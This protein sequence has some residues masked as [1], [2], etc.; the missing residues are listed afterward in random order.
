MVY[1]H[2][3]R[4]PLCGRKDVGVY[5]LDGFSLGLCTHG[6]YS[7][8]F[9]Q[10]VKQKRA[11][12]EI[13]QSALERILA[14]GIPGT[15]QC[16]EFLRNLVQYLFGS[17]KD[18]F[19]VIEIPTAIRSFTINWLTGMDGLLGIHDIKLLRRCLPS[20]PIHSIQNM[21]N[22]IRAELTACIFDE[23]ITLV[24]AMRTVWSTAFEKLAVVDTDI[25]E[26][27]KLWQA[28]VR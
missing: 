23:N 14:T 3:H 1:P 6:N 16:S 21:I 7:C 8:L 18:L 13:F 26:V 5:Y 28:H 17:E 24:T 12:G 11:P 19:G 10:V 27:Y 15:L 9:Y 20:L 4:C 25:H 2:K 22:V